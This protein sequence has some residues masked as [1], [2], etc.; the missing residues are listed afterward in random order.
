MIKPNRTQSR[1]DMV[2]NELARLPSIVL[3]LAVP[4]LN[5][6]TAFVFIAIL[7]SFATMGTTEANDAFGTF[8]RSNLP[9][10]TRII[11]FVVIGPFVET[12]LQQ[13]L[14]VKFIGKRLP[15]WAIILISMTVFGLFHWQTM[16]YMLYGFVHG[17]SYIVL[18]LALEKKIAVSPFW[19]VFLSHAL[20]N[21]AVL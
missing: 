17:F 4:L 3:V 6:A 7:T 12:F 9:L 18:Y 10:A 11:T 20:F 5:L 14:V 15:S 21:L 8:N 13:H 19:L 2:L 1:T 16:I